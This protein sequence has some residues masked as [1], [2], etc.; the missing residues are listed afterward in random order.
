MA[1]NIDAE[2][3]HHLDRFRPDLA[4]RDAGARNVKTVAG[5]TPQETFG[6]LA[7][8]GIAGAED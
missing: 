4:G 7:A 2:F 6:H 8:R 1:G 3:A 5:E